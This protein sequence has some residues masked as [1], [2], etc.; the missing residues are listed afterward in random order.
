MTT[1]TEHKFIICVRCVDVWGVETEILIEIHD[2]RSIETLSDFSGLA[3]Y[4]NIY[5][6]IQK[7][8]LSRIDAGT[9]FS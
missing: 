6:N 3:V 1:L 4:K 2:G 9:R 7:Q 5:K 8:M